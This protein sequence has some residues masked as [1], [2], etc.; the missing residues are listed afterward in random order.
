MIGT[1]KDPAMIEC[2]LKRKKEKPSYLERIDEMDK[3]SIVRLKGRITRDTIPTIDSR[4]KANRAAGETIDK[5]VVLDFARVDDV[6]S[7][8]VAFHII[9]LKE[10]HAKG[11]EV[12]FINLNEE[13]KA[14]VELFRENGT[15]KVFMSE[16]EAVQAL[17]R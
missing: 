12:G 9:H 4:I 1:R 17:N 16:A 11:F 14:L 3:L 15:F 13:M 2:F 6:D 8:T 10:F 5:N 7:A